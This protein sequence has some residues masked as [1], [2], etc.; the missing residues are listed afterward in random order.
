METLTEGEKVG[1]RTEFRSRNDGGRE[2][3]V[4]EKKRTKIHEEKS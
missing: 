3:W 4:D 2:M 1:N